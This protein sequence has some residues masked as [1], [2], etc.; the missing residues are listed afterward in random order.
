MEKKALNLPKYEKPKITTHTSE[1]ILE[2]IGPVQAATGYFT[3]EV[4]RDEPPNG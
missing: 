3:L 1:D 2:V 4:W